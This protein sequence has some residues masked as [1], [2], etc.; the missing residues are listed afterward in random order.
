MVGTFSL[1]FFLTGCAGLYTTVYV[2]H[3]DAVRL[4]QDVKNVKVWVKTKDGEIIPGKMTLPN[5]WYCL[6]LEEEDGN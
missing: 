3:G 6:P 1:L 5:G 2:P 4:R